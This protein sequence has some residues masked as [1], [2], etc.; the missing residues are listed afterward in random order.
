MTR[1]ELF[2]LHKE[3]CT[4]ALDLMKKKNSDYAGSDGNNPFANFTRAES[5]GICSTEQAFLVRMTD[6]MYGVQSGQGI[7]DVL[8]KIINWL[9]G[10]SKVPNYD[11]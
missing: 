3:M 7:M 1:E 10:S 6:K 8:Q 9:F 2:N 5:L 4:F 11:I